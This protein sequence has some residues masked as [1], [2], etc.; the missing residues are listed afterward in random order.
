MV[1]S[2]NKERNGEDVVLNL[3]YY[4]N[5]CYDGGKPV[6]RISGKGFTTYLR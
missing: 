6:I 1:K 5:T 2:L 4:G 3:K